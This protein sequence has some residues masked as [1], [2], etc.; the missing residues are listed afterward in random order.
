MGLGWTLV[1]GHNLARYTKRRE[2]K[3]N[4]E[5]SEAGKT[6]WA[7]DLGTGRELRR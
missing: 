3:M 4:A 5:T 2:K 6:I 1:F 7:F